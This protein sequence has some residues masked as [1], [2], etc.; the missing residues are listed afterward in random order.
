MASH[1]SLLRNCRSSNA[2][3]LTL[4]LKTLVSFYFIPATTGKSMSIL[5]A[6][7]QKHSG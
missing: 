4:T 5:L 3:Q 7:G 2:K 6:F 1:S